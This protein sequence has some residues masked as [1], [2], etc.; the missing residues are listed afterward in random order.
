MRKRIREGE[1]V[2]VD[3]VVVVEEYCVKQK[4]KKKKKKKK[5]TMRTLAVKKASLSKR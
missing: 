1:V 2:F 5:T 3:L 4:K